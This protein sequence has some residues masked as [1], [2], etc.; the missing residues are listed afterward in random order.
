MRS[1]LV[2]KYARPGTSTNPCSNIYHGPYINSE[3]EVKNVVD[4]ITERSKTQ[5]FVY[6][7]DIHSAALM[8]L[9]PYGYKTEHPPDYEDHMGIG[10]A[11]STAA[12]TVNGTWYP[13]GVTYEII[14]PAAGVA[15]DWGYEDAGIKYSLSLELRDGQYGFLLPERFIL[16]TAKETYAGMIASFLYIMDHP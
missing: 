3:V 4:F 13:Y 2:I 14:Y 1:I 15:L 9:S 6:F 11:F 16:P 10:E 8:M 12:Q 7:N 5:K